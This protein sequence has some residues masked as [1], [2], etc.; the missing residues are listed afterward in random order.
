MNYAVPSMML[1]TEFDRILYIPS[2]V[3]IKV[4]LIFLN[5]AQKWGQNM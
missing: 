3:K 1:M 5:L 4:F 2:N